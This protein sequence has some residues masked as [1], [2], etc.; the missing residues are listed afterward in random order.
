MMLVLMLAV[1]D[2]WS[3]KVCRV[4][5]VVGDYVVKSF[6]LEEVMARLRALIR[7]SMGYAT[8]MLFCG[9]VL[10]AVKTSRVFIGGQLIN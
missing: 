9:E 3:D 8:N 2:L 7:R 4:D 10:L 6:H 1:R 5:A